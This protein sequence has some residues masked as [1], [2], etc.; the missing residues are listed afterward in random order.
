MPRCAEYDTLAETIAGSGTCAKYAVTSRGT[1]TSIA[2]VTGF[3]ASGLMFSAMAASS[4]QNDL[5][6]VLAPSSC[7]GNRRFFAVRLASRHRA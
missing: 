7:Q 1:L 2:G 6:A 4:S 5:H 3:P